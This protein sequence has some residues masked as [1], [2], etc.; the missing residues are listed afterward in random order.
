MKKIMSEKKFCL[1]CMEE[2]DVDKAE[3]IETEMYKG[4]EVTFTATYE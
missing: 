4:Q 2:H 1:I 3:V